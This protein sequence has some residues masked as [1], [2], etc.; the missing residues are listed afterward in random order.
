MNILE[1]LSKVFRPS[2]FGEILVTSILFLSKC[3]MKKEDLFRLRPRLLSTSVPVNNFPTELF[4]L[5]Q[6]ILFLKMSKRAL[7]KSAIKVKEVAGQENQRSEYPEVVD[8]TSRY[9]FF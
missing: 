2:V 7:T 8:K 3:Q 1:L 9:T 4:W 5:H 6:V